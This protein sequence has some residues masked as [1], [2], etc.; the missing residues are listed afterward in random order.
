MT[1][2]LG[3]QRGSYK[4]TQQPQQRPQKYSS[5]VP[6]TCEVY[7]SRCTWPI[8]DQAAQVLDTEKSVELD[9][10]NNT[11]EQEMLENNYVQDST[12]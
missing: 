3:Y 6:S 8:K 5:L 9:K 1:N 7:S 11:K 2:S 10:L 4:R 12:N